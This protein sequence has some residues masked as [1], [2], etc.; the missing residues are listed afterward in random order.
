MTERAKQLGNELV[1][2][3]SQSESDFPIGYMQYGLTKREFFAAIAMQGMITDQKALAVICKQAEN[4]SIKV[5]MEGLC[6]VY[7][8]A[9]ADALLEKLSKTE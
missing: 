7:S 1:Y 8:V 5:T 6:A 4:E 9:Y 3:L 2:P